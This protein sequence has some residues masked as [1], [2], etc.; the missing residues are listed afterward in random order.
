MASRPSGFEKIPKYDKRDPDLSSNLL[1]KNNVGIG[2]MLEKGHKSKAKMI[3]VTKRF[4][5][6]EDKT[7]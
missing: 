5:S 1:V 3:L 2:G 7:V 4:Y 6:K